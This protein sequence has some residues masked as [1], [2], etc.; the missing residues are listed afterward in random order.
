VGYYGLVTKW[1]EL[2]R[3]VAPVHPAP[4]SP[5]QYSRVNHFKAPSREWTTRQ[6][7]QEKIPR[8]RMKERNESKWQD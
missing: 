8:R 5:S 2:L 4:V 3:H 1:Q 6:S 7:R